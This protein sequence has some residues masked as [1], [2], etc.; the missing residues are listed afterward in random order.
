MV[1]TN[2]KQ[3]IKQT[4]AR[5]L[6]WIAFFASV[7]LTL[8]SLPGYTQQLQAL[9]PSSSLATLQQTAIWLGIFLSIGAAVLCLVLALLVHVKRPGE[10]MSMFLSLFLLSY[11]I[12][13]VGPLEYFLLYWFPQ[14]YDLALLIQSIV[15][16]P[17]ACSL[18]LVFPNGRFTPRWTRWLMVLSLL[19]TAALLLTL[20]TD[21]WVRMTTTRARVGYVLFG[22]LTLL[23]MG[24]QFYRYRRVYSPI[25]RQ[26]TKWVLIGIVATILL[27]GAFAVPY[28]S[29]LNL[30]PGALRPWWEPI[31][32]A[33]WWFA[34]M[35]IPLS[36]TIAILRYRLWD[37]DIVIRRTLVYGALTLT[38]GLV[39]FSSVV[40]L[41]SLVTAAGGPRSA[42]VTVISTLLIAA[43]FNPLRKRIQNDIDRRFYRK[44]YDAEVIVAAFASSLREKVNLE[45]LQTQITAVVEDTLQPERLS[46]W[47]RP[48]RRQRSGPAPSRFPGADADFNRRPGR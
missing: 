40:L 32:S 17:V 28:Y 26:Q 16:S 29:L 19:L 33:G 11:G 42:V 6:W 7:I 31:G 35:L 5:W 47:L 15:F 1:E 13:M 20:N 41:Q 24:V 45:D 30:Q 43:L 34:M 39:F 9:D 2:N 27:S 8:A 12:I 18:L 22:V 48:V 25:E 44:K 4:L 36:L 38:L 23:A 14:S 3:E 21:E 46:L 37:I 10:S